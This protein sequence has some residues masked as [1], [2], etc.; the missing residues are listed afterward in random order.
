MEPASSN[1]PPPPPPPVASRTSTARGCLIALAVVVGLVAAGVG[2]VAYLRAAH[3]PWP[4]ALTGVRLEVQTPSVALSDLTEADT[5]FHLLTVTNDFK[6]PDGYRSEYNRLMAWGR[7]GWPY[8]AMAETCTTNG[9]LLIKLDSAARAPSN[10]WHISVAWDAPIPWLS[11]LMN[12]SKLNT[13]RA[14][15]ADQRGPQGAGDAFRR[16]SFELS[17]RLIPHGTLIQHLVGL[18]MSGVAAAELGDVIL[19]DPPPSP[20]RLRNWMEALPRYEPGD[21]TFTE[22]MRYEYLFALNAVDAVFSSSNGVQGV[23][24]PMSS[25]Q[26]SVFGRL[27]GSRPLLWM[28]GSTPRRVHDH[29]ARVYAHMV[30]ISTRPYEP[31]AMDRF[32]RQNF[33][34]N[35][36]RFMR[37][38]PLG[39]LMLA[40]LV[41]AM[42][43]ARARHLE[44][45]ALIRATL[46][47]C[48]LR[49]HQLDHGGQWPDR[50]D[51]LAPAYLPSLPADPFSATGE[52]FGYRTCPQDGFVLWSR[53]RDTRD[54]GGEPSIEE[55]SKAKD[56][57][58]GPSTIRLKR[59]KFDEEASRHKGAEPR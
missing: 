44:T 36:R 50:L 11:P 34:L 35:R 51:E 48:A 38:D 40:M 19:N 27:L 1:M 21:E 7:M 18:A 26:P 57:T 13:Y 47:M 49:L 4:E 29:V 46:I 5:Q 12:Y 3:S 20:E 43:S 37:D 45:V 32:F 24:G 30:D 58:Y 9:D 33:E 6:R 10:H 14:I 17:A 15:A 42:D 39:A 28:A 25:E 22:T 52:A 8:P 54:D 23:F 59:A 56:L 53:G 2:F 31:E 55:P 41:P 16:L